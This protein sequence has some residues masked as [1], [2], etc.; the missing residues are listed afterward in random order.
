MRKWLIFTLFILLCQQ[1]IK[2]QQPAYFLFGQDQFEGIDIYNVIQDFEHNYWFA[3]DQGLYVH[4]GYTFKKVESDKMKAHAVFNFV[5]DSR[6]VIYCCNLSQQVFKIEKGICSLIFEVPDNG[7]DLHLVVNKEDEL[8]ISTGRKAYILNHNHELIHTPKIVNEHMLGPPFLLDNG[9]VIQHLSN[10][11]KLL[12]Y[13]NKSSYFKSINY[14][15]D[16][17][18]G[19]NVLHFFQLN[20]NTF[21]IDNFNKEIYKVNPENFSTEKITD[22]IALESELLRY[23]AIDNT[24]W[25]SNHVSGVFLLNDSFQRT[26]KATKIF[27]D[28]FISYV[29]KDHEGNILLTT[30]DQGVIVIPDKEVLDVDPQFANYDITRIIN[31]AEDELYFGTRNGSI[32]KYDGRLTTLSQQSNKGVGY[33]FYWPNYQLILEDTRRLSVHTPG[34]KSI[35]LGYGSLKDIAQTSTN[36]LLLALNSGLLSVSFDPEKKTFLVDSLL[37]NERSNSV[38][39]EKNSTRTYVSTAS[40]LRYKDDALNYELLTHQGKTIHV[41]NLTAHKDEV[42]A[43]SSKSGIFVFKKGK[44]VREITPIYNDIPLTLFKIIIANNRIYANTQMG[45]FVINMKGEIINILNRSNGLTANKIIDFSLFKNQLWVAHAKG[46]QYFDLRKINTKVSKPRLILKDVFINNVKVKNAMYKGQFK[47]D[48]RDL[49]FSFQ[50]PTLRYRENIRYHFKLEGYLESWSINNYENHEVEYNALAP[51]SY[52][53]IVKAENNGVFSELIYYSFTISAPFYQRWWFIVLV[54]IAFG[55]LI[56]TA[57]MHQLRKQRRKAEQINELN[58]SRLTAIQSQ[59]NP[60]F[61]FNS[62]NSI[63]DLVLKG[64]IYNSYDFI[65]KFSNLVRRTLNY[66]D[67]DFIDFEQEISLIQ[68]Y[69]SLEKLRFKADLEYTINTNGIEDIKIPPMLIQPFIENALVHGLLHKA[70]K[71]QLIINFILEEVLICEIIDN[72]IGRKK[73]EEIKNRQ[74]IHH[75]SFAINAIKRRFT[76]LMDHYEGQLGFMMED[77]VSENEVIGTKVI[78]RIPIQSKF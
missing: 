59:M 34:E 69:L 49:K 24:V 77:I 12:I 2:A 14:S 20:K 70:G 54:L 50:S 46:I 30:F 10:Q 22:K 29:Y 67:K 68:L 8:Y 57:Y 3:T 48:E 74:G 44:V 4:D 33:L 32:L 5:I 45:L 43:A 52:R 31:G 37:L 39:R 72:G 21:C 61:I 40:G 76:I 41:I 51:G 25:V 53:F 18:K 19:D 7:T 16:D 11:S 26:H 63:Q 55:L 56:S 13:S 64:D 9:T 73:A 23:Y 75:E 17:V 27:D 1:S 42:F 35:Y 58:A 47:S 65:T 66:S 62:L 28:Y 36:G 71:K 15:N 38:V 6:G 60:H 78:L